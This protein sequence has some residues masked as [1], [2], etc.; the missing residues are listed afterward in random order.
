MKT[1][2]PY[3]ERVEKYVGISGNYDKL[4][5]LPDSVFQPPMGLT[6]GELVLKKAI[7]GMGEPLR[8]LTIGRVAIL[9]KTIHQG[10]F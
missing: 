8:R 9:T 7:D 4:P 6:C 1:L 10:Y 5:Q 3:Y 2:V